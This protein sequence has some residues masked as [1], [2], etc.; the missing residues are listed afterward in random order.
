MAKIS[1]QK[2]FEEI[3]KDSP[4]LEK[5]NQEIEDAHIKKS[6]WYTR[7]SSMLMQFGL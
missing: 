2:E 4:I 1:K 5:I 6:D 3:K 7:P